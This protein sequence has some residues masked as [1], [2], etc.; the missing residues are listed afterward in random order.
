LQALTTLNN[1]SFSEASRAMAQRLLRECNGDDH[2]RL[3][4][5]LRWCVARPPSDRELTAFAELLGESRGWYETHAD[6]AKAAIADCGI[7]GMPMAENAAWIATLR[8]ML[9]LDEFLTRE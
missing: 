2:Q 1:D 7:E 6:D 3:R 8:I 5:A 4:V 9:N